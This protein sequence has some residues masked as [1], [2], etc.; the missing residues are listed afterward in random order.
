VTDDDKDVMEQQRGCGI[1]ERGQRGSRQGKARQ[2]KAQ[3]TQA[4]RQEPEHHEAD[5][6]DEGRTR[7]D[8]TTKD[9]KTERRKEKTKEKRPKQNQTAR[10]AHKKLTDRSNQCAFFFSFFRSSAGDDEV[11]R[12]VLQ[13]PPFLGLP[14]SR[15]LL[16]SF[17]LPMT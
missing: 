2:G 15:L 8:P 16:A 12:G 7:H 17:F 13:T 5:T 14:A 10:R 3:Q 4:Q 1:G 6:R 11:G 9:G